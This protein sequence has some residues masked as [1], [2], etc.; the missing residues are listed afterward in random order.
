L[1]PN[2]SS[3]TPLLLI[4]VGF[5]AEAWLVARI[6]KPLGSAVTAAGVLLGILSIVASASGY[7]SGRADIFTSAILGLAGACTLLKPLRKVRWAA[8]VALIGGGVAVYLV[9]SSFRPG[10][11]AL[12]IVFLAV[13][14]LSYIVLKF[15][16]EALGLIGSFLAFPPVSILIGMVSIFQGVLMLLGRSLIQFVR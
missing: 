10:T 9:H 7:L 1:I 6:S 15:A 2:L 16:E 13:A 12:A 3:Y 14:V 5:A 8:L 11:I 4:A